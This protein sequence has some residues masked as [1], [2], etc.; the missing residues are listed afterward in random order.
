MGIGD[1][2][3][4][5]MLLLITAVFFAGILKKR[6]AEHCLITV[7]PVWQHLFSFFAVL[8]FFFFSA[9]VPPVSHCAFASAPV[10]SYNGWRLVGASQDGGT[11][12]LALTI[13]TCIRNECGF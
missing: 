11:I 3:L 2:I 8:F 13:A 6:T 9:V 10:C 1:G 7:T 4:K 12:L 5:R